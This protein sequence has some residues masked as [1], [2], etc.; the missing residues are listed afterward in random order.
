MKC[1]YVFAK[2]LSEGKPVF[3]AGKKKASCIYSRL[4]NKGISNLFADDIVFANHSF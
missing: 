2:W 1:K 4:F 3:Y